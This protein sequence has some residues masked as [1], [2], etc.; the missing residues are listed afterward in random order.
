MS[1]SAEQVAR[2][3]TLIP[4]LQGHQGVPVAEAARTFR[5]TPR[6]LVADLN[7]L[8][9]CGLPGG[10]PGDLIDIDMDAVEGDGRVS[11]TNAEYL[12][13][14]L[15]LTPDEVLSLVVALRV[16]AE[17]SG[18]DTVPA[19]ATALAKLEALGDRRDLERV[20]IQVAAGE[21]EVRDAVNQ[22][23]ASGHRLRL[24]Y[25]GL[26]RGE[27]TR[28]VVDPARIDL[29]DGA[30]YL[31]AWSLDRDAWRTYR[32]DRIAAA[33]PTGEQVADHGP[34][35][36][37]SAWFDDASDHN[38]VTLKLAPAAAWL[39]EYVPIIDSGTEPDGCVIVRLRV[40]DPAWLR[41]MLLRLGGDA[42]VLDPLDGAADAAV[43]A[44]EA[45]ALNA[46]VFG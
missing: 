22:A 31:Q 24:T 23:L 13:R 37:A 39:R 27:T 3:L 9:M 42:V 33:E 44:A 8:W 30:A 16:L 32:I 28:P 7:I 19:V 11:L 4:Y 41:A 17:V 21:S 20:A 5:I 35:P 36:A 12:A 6:Q 34:A 2:L 40:A 18:G 26:V 15:R 38:E 45:L 43:A 25:D 14:P 29:R 46:A 10:L 1:S